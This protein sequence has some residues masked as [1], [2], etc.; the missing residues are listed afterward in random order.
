MS[1]KCQK[2]DVSRRDFLQAAGGA[3]V[4]SALPARLPAEEAAAGATTKPSKLAAGVLGRTKYPVTR[5]SFGAIRIKPPDGTRLLKT[6]IDYGVNLVHTAPGYTGG[7]SVEAIGALFKEHPEYREK[8]FLCLKNSSPGD[9]GNVDNALKAMNTDH[10]DML[11]PTIHKAD[12]GRLE[13]IV[14][15]NELI[16]KKGKARFG[17][18]T[19]HGEMNEV[20]E[21]ILKEAPDAFD[22]TLMSMAPAGIRLGSS[23][24]DEA[25]EVRQRFLANIKGLRKQGV[26]IISMKSGAK[27]AVGRGKR[28]FEPHCK[29]VLEAG[30]DTVLTSFGNFNEVEVVPQLDLSSLAMTG[31]ERRLTAALCDGDCM[32]CGACT[33]ACPQGLPV[34][35]LV[36]VGSYPGS[37]DWA[38][39]A[40]GEYAALGVSA[41]QVASACSG[42]A[43]GCSGA[44]PIQLASGKHVRRV[45]AHFDRA[46][47]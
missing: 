11:M 27:R 31:F 4:V 33:H 40:V 13:T 23:K 37:A 35:D 19:S 46:L 16:V 2:S 17:A 28:L 1:E 9:E 47:A 15:F 43:G 12:P 34:A 39:H 10:A 36:R 42:C 41:A 14:K 29:S 32:M 44:C 6:A 25:D 30:A 8:V 22:G 45:A 20:I 7:K 26:G 18:F 5:V 24:Q 38:Q 3:V 21:L